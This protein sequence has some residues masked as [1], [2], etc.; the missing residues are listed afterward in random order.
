MSY[1]Y[2]NY[3]YPEALTLMNSPQYN[4]SFQIILHSFFEL[5]RKDKH[6][7]LKLPRIVEADQIKYAPYLQ[8][9][10]AN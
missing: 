2:I 4:F 10:R 3:K 1:Y 9:N 7:V 5:Q 8:Q 6:L